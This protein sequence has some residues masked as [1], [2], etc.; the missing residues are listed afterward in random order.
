[1]HSHC[2]RMKGSVLKKRWMPFIEK[3]ARMS[4]FFGFIDTG[5]KRSLVGPLCKSQGVLEGPTV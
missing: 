4:M 2:P 1:M 5:A 3:A